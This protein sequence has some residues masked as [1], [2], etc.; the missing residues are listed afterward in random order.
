VGIK[1]ESLDGKARDMYNRAGLIT[2]GDVDGAL[3]NAM[4][5]IPPDTFVNVNLKD[6]SNASRDGLAYDFRTAG[7]SEYQWELVLSTSFTSI[8]VRLTLDNLANIPKGVQF[9]LKDMHSGETM[10]VTADC[11][12]SLTLRAG[13]AHVY[14]LTAA[15]GPGTTTGTEEYRPV[16]FGITGVNPNP[17]NPSTSIHFGL[18]KS[19]TVKLSI[20]N[21]TGQCMGIL[22][23]GAMSPGTH[24]VTW[25]AKGCS[26]GVYLVVLEADGKRDVRKVSLV[27]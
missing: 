10:A 6:P 12:L 18:E 22:K 8:P 13:V 16:S 2:T 4:D 7:E 15:M 5:L 25:N 23:E 26:S 1:L 11:S 24:S 19:G 27:K 21:I 3:Y 17:F 14:L 20:Y 9:A